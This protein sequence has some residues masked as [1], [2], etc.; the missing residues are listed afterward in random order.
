MTIAARPPTVYP[1]APAVPLS[2]N[3]KGRRAISARAIPKAPLTVTYTWGPWRRGAVSFLLPPRLRMAIAGRPP[4]IYPWAPSRAAKLQLA[5]EGGPSNQCTRAILKARLT[6]T[7]TW[8][9]W[10]RGAANL[11]L[12]AAA[13]LAGTIWSDLAPRH[14]APHADPITRSWQ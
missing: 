8:G 4:S 10:R 5:P 1:W 3:P 9:P 6:V 7:Y 14:P 12:P 2:Y 11:L 13:R